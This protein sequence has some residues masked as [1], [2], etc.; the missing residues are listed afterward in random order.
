MVFASVDVR[1]ELVAGAITAVAG[2]DGVALVDAVRA[3]AVVSCATDVAVD[4]PAGVPVTTAMS[5]A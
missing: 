2:M 4:D 1:A 3:S 5:E